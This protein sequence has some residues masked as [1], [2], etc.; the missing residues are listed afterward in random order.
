MT[1]KKV[2]LFSLF[3]I[4][5]I[6]LFLLIGGCQKENE[7][8]A[9]PDPGP[10]GSLNDTTIFIVEGVTVT[11]GFTVDIG[12]SSV[13]IRS[14]F[15]RVEASS[16]SI[17]DHG[18][19]VSRTNNP[20]VLSNNEG[21]D[22][23]GEVETGYS[24]SFTSMISNL[25]PNTTYYAKVFVTRKDNVTGDQT[26][27]HPPYSITFK[28]QE[29]V[30]PVLTDSVLNILSNSA[31][32]Y[33][34]IEDFSS[35]PVTEH[36][37]FWS[38]N[39]N[40]TIENNEGIW[41]VTEDIPETVS[42]NFQY[43]ISDLNAATT[44]YVRAYA[45]NEIGLGL[46]PLRTFTTLEAPVP[47]VSIADVTLINDGNSSGDVNPGEE[48]T[49][50]VRLVNTGEANASNVRLNLSSNNTSNGPSQI[51]YQTIPQGESIEKLVT[52]QVNGNVTVGNNFFIACEI[53]SDNGSWQYD[54]VFEVQVVAAPMPLVSITDITLIS[55]GNG[56]GD[57]N[58]G[59]EVTYQVRLVNTGEADA[60]NVRLNLS[61]SNISNEPSQI[62]YQTIPQGE[63]AEKLVTFQVNGNV[64][65]GNDFF[66]AC[67]I[68]SDGE[69]WQYNNVFEVQV[70]E[71]PG[72]NITLQSTSVIFD[73]N[74]DGNAN[75]GENITLNVVLENNGNLVANEV[76]VVFSGT[77]FQINSGGTANY[78]A[79]TP[80]NTKAKNL[81]IT[82][83]EGLEW[84]SALNLNLSI[85]DASGSQWFAT[86]QIMVESPFCQLDNLIA[87]YNFD[88]Q[89][90]NNAIGTNYNAVEVGNIDYSSDRPG[91]EGYS[92]DFNADA[93]EYFLE[94]P[95]QPFS[96]NFSSVTLSV[97][98]KTAGD[99]CILSVGNIGDFCCSQYKLQFSNDRI[100]YNTTSGSFQYPDLSSTLL[101]NQW[102]HMAITVTGGSQILYVNGQEVFSNNLTS[103]FYISSIIFNKSMVIGR[104]PSEPNSFP[105][106]GKLDNIRIYNV[107]LSSS[108]I[109]DI[110]QCEQN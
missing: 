11:N 13:K 8:P 53:T 85:E 77:G 88:D 104:N 110:Y 38:T 10:G 9:G 46:G 67:G 98:I 20:H 45:R 52:F 2:F 39:S 99:G 65:A 106:D 102:E 95:S 17:V 25:E 81:E 62:D 18:H 90:G 94:Q 23:L 58:P 33:G 82:L 109:L 16:F 76:N 14:N 107:A 89:N 47:L 32:V 97:W 60:S 6:S 7:Q 15:I 40:M 49:Y 34:N 74:N 35:L 87:F 30:E 29:A 51:N 91:S 101:T 4:F 44:Y 75:P 57:V 48:V 43:Q 55:D 31:V 84:G 54:N 5:S 92:V 73:E 66:I 50:Q 26:P 93:E 22:S 96:N 12:V 70:V 28:T 1:I 3:M 103:G 24:G 79:I 63:S 105:F 100:F 41:T 21:S 71:A 59:E 108:D 56:S 78:G 72:P 68:T 42:H 80:G 36:G 37:F 27:G 83:D 69:S 64:P 61:S 19:V 86:H